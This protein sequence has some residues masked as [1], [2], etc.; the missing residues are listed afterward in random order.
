[1]ERFWMEPEVRRAH[2][3]MASLIP[4]VTAH[5]LFD[6]ML[7]KDIVAE[8][9]AFNAPIVSSGFAHEMFDKNSPSE[10][11][12]DRDV[13][14]EFFHEEFVPQVTW[15][16]M[17]N[18]SSDQTS[19]VWDTSAQEWFDDRSLPDVIWDEEPVHELPI[20]DHAL[21]LEP[22]DNVNLREL[23]QKL[24]GSE[25]AHEYD[26]LANGQ[27]HLAFFA[28]SSQECNRAQVERV[29]EEKSLP[30]DGDRKKSNKVGNLSQEQLVQE[31]LTEFSQQS[32]YLTD[33]ERAQADFAVHDGLLNQLASGT[34]GIDGKKANK[35][36]RWD[37]Y[38]PS[39][40]GALEV[41]NIMSVL[42]V[43][44]QAEFFSECKEPM[45][46]NMAYGQIS[47]AEKQAD[48][49]LC[50]TIIFHR[51]YQLLSLDVK[52]ERKFLYGTTQREKIEFNLSLDIRNMN[53]ALNHL[54]EG[55]TTLFM[56]PIAAS[57]KQGIIKVYLS[58]KALVVS[59]IVNIRTDGRSF[60]PGNKVV[61][62][63]IPSDLVDEP[64]MG[65]GQ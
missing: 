41:G 51:S 37:T 13:S 26:V 4:G 56:F 21:L 58:P 3:P 55:T 45:Q 61:C 18:L 49:C 25:V 23:L 27:Q 14:E 30:S 36:F 10:V 48:D 8:Q 53:A 20:C 59:N 44:K 15:F 33:K 52:S 16:D 17:P 1:M 5:E 63:D 54:D 60:S 28:D 24:Q 43:N 34:D 38:Q 57:C 31:D 32:A 7:H 19:V 22:T 47:L 35:I 2:L 11:I 40:K 62:L 64:T 50:G 65:S 39:T 12:W 29:E 46:F 9:A 42:P 6:H